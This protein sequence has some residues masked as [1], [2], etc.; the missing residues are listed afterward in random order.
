MSIDKNKIFFI[1]ISSYPVSIIIGPSVSL[2]NTVFIIGVYLLI[3][4]K[5]EHYKF[6]FKNQ[7][8]RMFLLLYLYLIINSLFSINYEIGLGR[9]L[10]FVRLIILFI[11]INYFFYSSKINLKFFYIWTTIFVIFLLDVNLERFSGTNIFG[12]G[13]QEIDG[14]IQPDGTRVVSFFKDEPISGSFIY[15]FIFLILGYLLL[16]LKNKTKGNYLFLFLTVF[17]LISV[18]LTG[19]RSNTIKVIFGAFLF[20]VIIDTIKPKTKVLILT[21]L[22]GSLF[23]VVSNSSYLKNRY[24]GQFYYYILDKD[25][26]NLTN[27]L[28]YKLYNSGYNVFKNSPIFGV[29]NK[30]YRIE[31]CGDVEKVKK[32]NYKCTTHPHQ[33]YIEFLSEHGLLGTII[34]LSLFFTLIFKNYKKMILSKNYIQLGCF[35]YLISVFLPLLPSGSFFSDFN[36]TFFFINLSLFYAVD[37]NT[38]IFFVEKN[39]KDSSF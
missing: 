21:V 10:G 16:V 18:V 2:V 30:N 5:N 26:K 34:L 11:A 8:L 4:F 38:N 24:I 22:V 31:S 13:A 37:K 3:F 14:V 33:I 17:F 29:G 32:F 9:N 35:C 19:E 27:S 1:L 36:L 12:W 7:T 39:N 6:L 20:I 25:S 15:G 28:Y 23:L